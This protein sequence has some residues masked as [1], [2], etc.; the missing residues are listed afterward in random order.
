MQG[1]FGMFGAAKCEE[2]T[3]PQ[4]R[5]FPYMYV[6]ETW[7]RFHSTSVK[8]SDTRL[9]QP[10]DHSFL[11]QFTP[12]KKMASFCNFTVLRKPVS[13]PYLQSA[14]PSPLG[15]DATCPESFRDAP[16]VL[17]TVA[18]LGAC[19]E[20]SRS[21]RRSSAPSLVVTM[22]AAFR[23]RRVERFTLSPNPFPPPNPYV[24]EP[25]H[26]RTISIHDNLS[27]PKQDKARY[28]M[29]L[30]FVSLAVG[31]GNLFLPRKWRALVLHAVQC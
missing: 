26:R 8:V 19:T 21:D 30:Y 18:A 10:I 13:W 24:K 4:I 11:T 28:L 22:P 16:R 1:C 29:P 25:R 31:A 5:P 7:L 15:S 17:H 9:S 23:P 12:L 27:T 3:P 2:L 6:P 14:N 20:R